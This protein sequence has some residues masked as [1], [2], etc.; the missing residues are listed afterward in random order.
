MRVAPRAGRGHLVAGLLL[1]GLALLLAGVAVWVTVPL[2]AGGVFFFGV[3]GGV[4][5]GRYL[6]RRLSLEPPER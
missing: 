4:E 2:A 6:E 5:L 3:W 1:V